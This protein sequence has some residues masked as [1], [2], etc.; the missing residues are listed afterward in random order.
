ME[1]RPADYWTKKCPHSHLQCG[2]KE[3][4]GQSSRAIQM[5]V[6]EG[7][8]DQCGFGIFSGLENLSS[9]SHQFPP[10]REIREALH[11]VLRK[12]GGFNL[13]GATT[14]T[15]ALDAELSQL[16]ERGPAGA[17]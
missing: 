7:R 4:V 2:P 8:R 15:S 3:S 16:T 12:C 6:A 11:L 10:V 14:V 13:N 17:R 1:K 5:A 9:G